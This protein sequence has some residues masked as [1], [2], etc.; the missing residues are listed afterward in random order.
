MNTTPI[1]TPHQAIDT[2]A[3]R[4]Y[5]EDEVRQIAQESANLAVSNL[6]SKLM[7]DPEH[8]D[9]SI[10]HSQP[11]HQSD[12]LTMT[13]PELADQLGISK[14]IAYR[15]IRDGSIRSINIGH[16]ILIPRQAVVEYLNC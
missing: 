1:L 5:N 13:V 14:P 10:S 3:T 8:L 4:L 6:L 15:L 12:R 16:K 7:S 2:A 11:Y 9:S